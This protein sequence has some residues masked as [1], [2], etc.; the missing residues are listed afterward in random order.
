MSNIFK[1]SFKEF[2]TAP[3][4][5][6]KLF[7]I[8]YYKHGCDFIKGKYRICIKCGKRILR[9]EQKSKY[10]ANCYDLVNLPNL[11]DYTKVCV[12]CGSTKS[13]KWFDT[14]DGEICSNCNSGRK[15]TRGLLNP[16]S[17]AGIAVITE[18]ITSIALG[19]CIKCNIL[20]NFNAKYDLISESFG[21]INVK[22]S[23]LR[24]NNAWVFAVRKY[25]Y[26]PD[27]YICIGFNE[28]RTKIQHVWIIPGNSNIIN[29]SGIR[30][31]NSK[32]GLN[33][34]KEY[35]LY[36]KIYDDIYKL[37]DIYTLP[38]FKNYPKL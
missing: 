12:I 38:E 29:N 30:I 8:G 27:Y 15:Y 2:I 17:S 14:E 23:I 22:S 19:D 10:C 35:E 36:Y 4:T 16:R 32:S 5:P 25:T 6:L 3:S 33:R 31:A 21:N 11:L 13:C 1:Y 20:D 26:T 24:L 34:V 18:H 28:D 9:D 7:N 37:L